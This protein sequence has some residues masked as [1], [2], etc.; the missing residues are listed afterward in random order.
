MLRRAG[1]TA[2]GLQQLRR[3][4]DLAPE[5]PLHW[6]NLAGSQFADG[7][8]TEAR[9]G[10]ERAVSMAPGHPGGWMGLASCHLHAGEVD[11]AL[12]AS[13]RGL[14]LGPDVGMH[15]N[16]RV[17]VLVRA[18][19]RPEAMDL[20]E[21]FVTRHPGDAAMRSELLMGLQ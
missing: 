13:A 4:C 6:L 7:A 15:V 16:T 19:R 9:K 5:N 1:E 2:Q 8:V 14:E 12:A 21:S 10:F 20:L 17:T 11:E 18:G 3:A